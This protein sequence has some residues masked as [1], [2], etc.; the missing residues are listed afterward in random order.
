MILSPL[1]LGSGLPDL[2]GGDAKAAPAYVS[3]RGGATRA[4]LLHGGMQ[5]WAPAAG[6]YDL[7]W[8]QWV[9]GHLTD[10]HIV[11]FLRRCKVRRGGRKRR[12]NTAF[13]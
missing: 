8:I 13:K 1:D 5:T 10:V 2:G 9:I 6:A 12:D 4:T 11:A 3:A 7:V